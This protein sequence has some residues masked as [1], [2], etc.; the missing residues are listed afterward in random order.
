MPGDARANLDDPE[1]DV[2]GVLD[3]ADDELEE[4]AALLDELRQLDDAGDAGDPDRFADASTE[5]AERAEAIAASLRAMLAREFVEAGDD[6][7][8]ADDDDVGA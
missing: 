2:C 3:G 5:A 6:D 4:I 1:L 8:E 7:G